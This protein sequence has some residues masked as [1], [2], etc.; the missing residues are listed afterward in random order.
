MLLAEN[1]REQCKARISKYLH[2][3]NKSVLEVANS[4]LCNFDWLQ[5][6]QR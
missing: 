4:D 1:N 2:W 6:T 5:M 3:V